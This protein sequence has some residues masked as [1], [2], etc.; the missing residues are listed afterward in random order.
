ML[1]LL[2]PALI[3]SWRFFAMV[4]P[5]P[6]IEL[7]LL[8]SADEAPPSWREF[9]PRPAHVPLHAILGRL[10]WNPRWNELLFLVTC[11]ERVLESGS[12][13]RIRE[14]LSRIR[15][16]LRRTSPPTGT[17]QHIQMRFVVLTRD[18]DRVVREEVYRSAVHA[19]DAEPSS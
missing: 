11:T 7:A 2:L 8:G 4:A 10:L 9:R 19:L 18:K 1:A 3:P 12:E 16:D 6:R 17:A 14:I 15:S 5:S 13:R